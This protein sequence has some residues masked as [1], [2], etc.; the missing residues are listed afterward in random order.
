MRCSGNARERALHRCRAVGVVESDVGYGLVV[1]HQHVVH[2]QVVVGGAGRKRLGGVGNVGI[3]ES[4]VGGVAYDA[5]RRKVDCRIGLRCDLSLCQ[6]VARC[7]SGG[8]VVCADVGRLC[9]RTVEFYGLLRLP[10]TSISAFAKNASSASLLHTV[11]ASVAP[12]VSF[13]RI[14]TVRQPHLRQ[15]RRLHHTS[16]RLPAG[17]ARFLTIRSFLR[18]QQ[19]CRQT[20][21]GLLFSLWIHGIFQRLDFRGFAECACA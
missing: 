13:R 2:R 9:V 17:A 7:R 21:P 15:P 3:G 8:K 6:G 18:F 19:L 20:L 5:A 4:H 12:L 10:F 11:G 1:W 14:S 16:C